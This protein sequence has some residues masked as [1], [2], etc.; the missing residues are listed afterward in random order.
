MW[1]LELPT[2][3]SPAHEK[4]FNA[5]AVQLPEETRSPCIGY[6]QHLADLVPHHRE[7]RMMFGKFVRI[8]LWDTSSQLRPT[9]ANRP[10]QGSWAQGSPFGVFALLWSV[11]RS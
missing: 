6:V 11:E 9:N 5:E 3:T 4:A 8:D 7:G 1:L 2:S 10:H